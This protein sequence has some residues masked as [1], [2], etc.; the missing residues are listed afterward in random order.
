VDPE[1]LRGLSIEELE[2][3]LLELHEARTRIKSQLE[4]SALLT[5][6]M[7]VIDFNWKKRANHALRCKNFEYK[8][9]ERIVAEKRKA[10][11]Q[12]AHFEDRDSVANRFIEAARRSLSE[13]T[14]DRLMSEATHGSISTA[15]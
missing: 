8:L 5:N 3:K 10:F 2:A 1:E 12:K 6:S 15:K 11:R 4:E 9:I 14:F 13:A 7:G